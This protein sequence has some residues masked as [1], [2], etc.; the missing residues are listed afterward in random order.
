MLTF[1]KHFGYNGIMKIDALTKRKRRYVELAERAALQSCYG[2]IKHG[3]VLVKG[4]S[5]LNVS[6]NKANHCRFGTRFRERGSG[7]ATLHA[8]LGCVLNLDRKVT[9]GGTIYVVRL[10]RKGEHRMSKPCAMC[11]AALEHVGVNRVYY[12]TNDKTLEMMRL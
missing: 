2:N 6:S 12:S 1:N 8:E 4:G 5:V 11:Q 7:I 10:N 9:E 3:A